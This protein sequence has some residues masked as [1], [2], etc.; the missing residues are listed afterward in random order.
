[1]K[2]YR[3]C[4]RVLFVVL[5]IASVLAC[6]APPLPTGGLQ[7]L[8]KGSPPVKVQVNGQ[9][10]AQVACN[11]GELLIPG[12]KGLP[13]LP[14]DVRVISVG[15]SRTLLDQR[16]TD[17]PRWLLVQRDSAGVSSSPISGPFVPCP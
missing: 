11:G 8:S 17:L 3:N 6:S 15:D 14:W 7:I 4:V 1:M 16:I 2:R 9:D 5:V 13:G 12:E 10:V